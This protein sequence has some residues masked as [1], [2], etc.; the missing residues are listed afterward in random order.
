MKITPALQKKSNKEF[1]DILNKTLRKLHTTYE[2]AFW[3]FNMG[4]AKYAKIQDTALAA[5]D[6]FSGSIEILN[7][8]QRRLVQAKG[9]EK[10][11]LMYWQRYFKKNTT[12][13]E[14]RELRAKI[15]ELESKVAVIRGTRKEG[16]IDPTTGLFVEASE[17]A[18]RGLV[19]T[20]P[21]EAIRKACFEATEKLISTTINE[22]V[23]LV[24]LRNKF[25]QQLGFSDF[26][27][28]KVDGDE[29][30][31]TSELF[32]IFDPIYNQTKYVFDTIRQL[33]KEKP[34]LRKPWNFNY[35]MAGNFT[36]EEDPYFQ[37]D[38]ALP[39][40]A[41]TFAA[42]G[43]DFK[44]GAITLDLLDRKGKTNNG[45]CHWPRTV[46]YE[47]N[48]RIPG[49]SNFTCTLVPGQI[50][51]G[52]NGLHTL[53][54][55]GGH[56]AHLLNSEERDVCN[57]HEYAPMSMSWAETQS[58]SMD[59]ISS[60]IE[61]R[62]RY[63]KNK[64]GA[65][66][67]FELFERKTKA[68]APLLP[69]GMMSMLAM[70][71]FERNVYEYPSDTLTAEKVMEFAR[72]AS[73]KYFDRDGDSH[74]PLSV[75]HI[76]SWDSAANYYGYA[77]ADIVVAQWRDYF[78]KKYEYIVDNP[79]VGKEMAKVWK[80]GGRYSTK[81]FVRT[82]MNTEFNVQPYIDSITR[83]VPERITLAQERIARL[84]KVRPYTKPI[85]LKAKITL[86]HGRKKIADN[87]KGFDTM[88]KKYAAWLKRQEPKSK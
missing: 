25:A 53:F 69:L 62:I 64:E 37:F 84:A 39:M 7:E 85:D 67:P 82:A 42:L 21:D 49:A 57:S 17:L 32:A 10:N 16:Y 26:Y 43:I 66:Y 86:V 29:E 44:G 79:K 31:S 73:K 70:M 3:R 27:A 51:E 9:V 75:F 60:S 77:L 1:L 45:F 52:S 47:K 83:T 11:R 19:R 8:V 35:M 87:S 13:P 20:S 24:Q 50:G 14:V 38:Q 78:Y 74:W 18:L 88:T 81:E 56:A 41:K 48:R 58:M 36:K 22:Y 59:N 28:Y 71:S 63:A 2:N 12:P 65:P 15:A 55:E 23:E 30:M 33:E 46:A 34:G 5:R 4:E 6:H 80:F 76:Y 40:W 72:E 68:L 54:H 61:W